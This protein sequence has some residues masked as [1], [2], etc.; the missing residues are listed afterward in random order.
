MNIIINFVSYSHRDYNFEAAREFFS[1]PSGNEA[2]QDAP[3][4]ILSVRQTGS[5]KT[6]C[7]FISAYNTFLSS[8]STMLSFFKA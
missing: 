4:G 7:F 8:S 5:Y 6:K 1:Q 2:L 3:K